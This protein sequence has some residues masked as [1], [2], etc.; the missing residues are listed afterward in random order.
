ML[1]EHVIT[2]MGMSSNI[3]TN[4]QN[5]TIIIYNQFI[6]L[7]IREHTHIFLVVRRTVSQTVVEPFV[8]LL[9]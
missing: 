8:V 4:T 7:A 2:G 5:K 3:F 1:C 9:R 6:G